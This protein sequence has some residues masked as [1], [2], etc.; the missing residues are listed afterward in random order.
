[1]QSRLVW[2]AV[3]KLL[4]HCERTVWHFQS[5]ICKTVMHCGALCF[6]ET[7]IAF[8][9]NGTFWNVIAVLLK[10][11]TLSHRGNHSLLYLTKRNETKRNVR[12]INS[13]YFRL[14]LLMKSA[15]LDTDGFALFHRHFHSH[16]HPPNP[17]PFLTS[18]SVEVLFKT[19]KLWYSLL[20]LGFSCWYQWNS[21]KR[22]CEA[23]SKWFWGGQCHLYSLWYYRFFKLWR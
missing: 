17:P 19:F 12:S 7:L 6:K 11:W 16:R 1:M 23:M 5:K 22:V 8:Q 4:S 15:V 20:P 21:W 18:G 2:T 13:G 9:W 10:L 14:I 3:G